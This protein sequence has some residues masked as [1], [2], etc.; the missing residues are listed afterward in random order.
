MTSGERRIVSMIN[1]NIHRILSGLPEPDL[2]GADRVRFG[3][4]PSALFSR[5]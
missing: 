1:F 2:I 4:D 3:I 5:R